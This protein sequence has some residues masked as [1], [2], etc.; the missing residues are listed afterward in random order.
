MSYKI[1]ICDDEPAHIAKIR[2]ILLDY[3]T[4]NYSDPAALLKAVSE[5]AHFDI[6]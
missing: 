2:N 1:A 3:E 6:S 5:G 4:I